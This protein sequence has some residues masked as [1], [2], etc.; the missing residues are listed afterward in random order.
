MGIAEKFNKGSKFTFKAD[1]PEGT[2][3]YYM[4]AKELAEEKE[5]LVVRS[6]YFNKKGK[7]DHYVVVCTDEHYDEPI[8]LD[9]PAH[10]T[11]TFIEMYKDDEA[12][13]QINSGELGVSGYEYNS[14]MRKE[15]CYGLRF[16]DL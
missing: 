7:F 10:M 16:S 5:T 1:L 3:P 6:F 8:F 14:K 9:A 12:I 13:E 2:S 11:E 4:S 15:P